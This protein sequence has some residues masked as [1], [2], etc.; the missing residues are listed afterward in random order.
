MARL[1]AAGTTPRRSV[2]CSPPAGRNDP[3]PCGSGRKAKVLATNADGRSVGGSRGMPRNAD[4]RGRVTSHRQGSG[5]G[6]GGPGFG[7][8]VPFC[9]GPAGT[10]PGSG[11][12]VGRTGDGVDGAAADLSTATLRRSV[13]SGAGPVGR[14]VPP[15]RHVQCT[16]GVSSTCCMVAR[17]RGLVQEIS[18]VMTPPY[19][20][21]GRRAWPRSRRHSHDHLGHRPAGRSMRPQPG[22]TGGCRLRGRRRSTV[23][24]AAK[25]PMRSVRGRLERRRPSGAEGP[26]GRATCGC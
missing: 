4:P 20:W 7:G 17:S 13:G 14:P 21:P 25:A 15:V 22:R 11:T 12:P 19:G 23:P 3:C 9:R 10:P 1:L 26:A 24:H 6:V 18:D 2:T 5:D 8:A 16:P